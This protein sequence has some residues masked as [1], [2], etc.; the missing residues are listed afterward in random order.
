MNGKV[1]IP[2]LMAL[3]LVA[4]GGGLSGTFEV[5]M[6]MSAYTFHGGGRVVQSSPP[7]G[8]GREMQYKLDGQRARLLLSGADGATLLLITDGQKTDV[9][10]HEVVLWVDWGVR[11]HIEN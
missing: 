6:G 1:M 3:L 5:E 4:C 8:A 2:M 11:R 10:D 9:V 7:V